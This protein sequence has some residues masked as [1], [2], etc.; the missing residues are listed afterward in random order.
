MSLESTIPELQTGEAKDLIGLY[1][2]GQ[3]GAIEEVELFELIHSLQ[4]KYQKTFKL[5]DVLKK[6]FDYPD[7]QIKHLESEYHKWLKRQE[8]T[9]SPVLTPQ[10]PAAPPL[11]EKARGVG[12]GATQALLGETQEIGNL[13][14]LQYAP[15][16]SLRGETLKNYVIKCIEY[17]EQYGDKM[18]DITQENAVL[19]VLCQMFVQV[20]KPQF[21]QMAASRMYLD[22][23]TELM[24]LK[25]MG[26][27]LDDEWVNHITQKIEQAMD[28][29]IY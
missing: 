23:T 13:L 24:Q 16:A 22:W 7:Y 18:E 27:D 28:I 14:V 25:V 20:V 6:S 3:I 4:E 8:N 29:K 10:G 2:N 19:K 9:N 12:K 5:R 11:I 17:R 15:N 26:I 21:R 1:K